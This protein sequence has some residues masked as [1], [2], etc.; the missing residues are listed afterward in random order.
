MAMKNTG[1]FMATS[2]NLKYNNN[3]ARTLRQYTLSDFLFL[4]FLA[5]VFI[6]L[7]P[8]AIRDF[9][10]ITNLNSGEGNATRQIAYLVMFVATCAISLKREGFRSLNV[11]PIPLMAALGWFLLSVTWSLAP[12]I[13]LRRIV[14]SFCAILTTFLLVRQLGMDRSVR[15][16][17]GFLAVLIA[18]NLISIFILPQAVH[19]QG[20]LDQALV[21]N[22]RGLYFHKNIA[23][24]MAALS[25]IAFL[26][27]FWVEK[28]R[29]ALIYFSLAIVFV[30]GSMSKTSMA[31]LPIS[32]FGAL[33]CCKFRSDPIKWNNFLRALKF[34]TVF[35]LL[36]ALVFNGPIIEYLLD[37]QRFTGRGTIW[38]TALEYSGEHLLTGSGFAAFWGIGLQ[39][40]VLR[41]SEISWLITVAHSHSGYIELL[42]TT[43]IIGL[44]L[45]LAATFVHPLSMLNSNRSRHDFLLY[46]WIIFSFLLN[47][48]ETRLF[49]MVRE[50]WIVHVLAIALIYQTS[51]KKVRT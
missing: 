3:D 18:I 42:V 44:A 31:I 34:A 49:Q 9:N 13:S 39:S 37:P 40:P 10:K 2:L 8:F 14:L 51:A 50:D 21:G 30:V 29:S 4:S 11:L 47:F 45:A 35:V 28:K 38:R 33:L 12:D 27:Q 5:L 41:N 19:T 17:T 22:W 32:I 20:E 23:G 46:G 24:P 6:G 16:L 1:P 7:E 36:V 25:A 43:G 26:N 15:L 48:T